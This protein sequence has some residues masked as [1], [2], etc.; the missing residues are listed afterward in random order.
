[1]IA[2]LLLKI[3][4]HFDPTGDPL[5]ADTLHRENEATR[6]VDS[7]RD[8][9]LADPRASGVD[10]KWL[11]PD[12]LANALRARID[13]RRRFAKL[14]VFVPADHEDPV[15]FRV[16]DKDRNCASF[17]NSLFHPFGSG[18]MVPASGVMLRDCGQSLVLQERHPNTIAPNARPMH[19]IIPGM[20]KR[21]VR[22]DDFRCRE[23]SLPGN[24]ARPFSL[25]SASS[26]VGHAD[27]HRP[28]TGLPAPRH[29]P[30]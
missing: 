27:G 14:P 19:A 11:L 26:R 13:L 24:E 16:V 21:R 15:Y 18:L 12:R 25:E 6:L 22:P 30:G 1:V 17:T 8:A 5:G 7:I 2:L 10:V 23:R 29:G 3:L 4:Q 9:V 28:S 20:V